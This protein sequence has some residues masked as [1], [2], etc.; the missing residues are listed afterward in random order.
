MKY[1]TN[2]TKR[3]VEE[4]I[5]VPNIRGV[6]AKL[7]V[8]HSTF[9]RWMSKHHT[10]FKMVTSALTM[11]RDRMSDAAEGVVIRGIQNNNIK[12]AQYWLSHNNSRYATTMQQRKLHKITENELEIMN[13]PPPRNLQER[14]FESMF[15]LY[16]QTEDI[17][18]K[19]K[20][21]QHIEKF[22]TMMCHG[23]SELEQIF[24]VAYEEWRQDKEEYEAKDKRAFPDDYS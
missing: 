16:K 19:E 18:P 15:E 23:D 7:N 3:F 5:K 21:R 1:D 9:Y 17:F 14:A 22:V 20:A 13:E 12:A 4:L 8:D 24:F 6:C 10:F 2:I 11:G